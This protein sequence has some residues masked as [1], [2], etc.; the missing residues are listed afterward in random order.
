MQ[1]IPET[2][3]LGSDDEIFFSL[4]P[5]ICQLG[6][7][8]LSWYQNA[9][10]AGKQLD[11]IYGTDCDTGGWCSDYSKCYYDNEPYSNIH[12]DASLPP[13]SRHYKFSNNYDGSFTGWLMYEKT[14][15]GGSDTQN[16]TNKCD[17]CDGWCKD[18]GYCFTLYRKDSIPW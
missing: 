18:N 2:S 10:G 4:Y 3:Q 1:G 12:D 13:R 11:P 9:G 17:S 15:E 6:D 7:Q 5:W 8:D 14:W 16:Y